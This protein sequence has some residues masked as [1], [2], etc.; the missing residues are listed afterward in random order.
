MLELV[1]IKS[2]YHSELVLKGIDLQA[3]PNTIH[4]V[5]GVNGAGKTTLFR[6]ICGDLNRR[7]GKILWQGKPVRRGHTSFLVTKPNFY[8]YMKGKEY[9]SLV[10]RANPN[11]DYE[12]WNA[13]FDLPLEAMVREYSTGMKKKIAFLAAIAQDRPVMIL[14][15]PFN[16]VDLE[17]N[18]K[19][20]KII[21]RLRSAERVILLASH[22]IDSLVQIA[23]RISL[24]HDGRIQQTVEQRDFSSWSQQLKSELLGQI[25]GQLDQLLP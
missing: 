18:E 3:E 7:D 17:S 23:D 11:F 8:P 6:T 25:A 21:Q 13:L 12:E 22:M 1:N 2:G 16:G 5:L 19:L 24:L 14:D 20:M 10:A 15:E 9:L 4:G